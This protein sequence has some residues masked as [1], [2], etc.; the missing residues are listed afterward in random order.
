M[1]RGNFSQRGTT[2]PR[3][4]G[5]RR[6]AGAHHGAAAGG[7]VD[8]QRAVE[9]F[10]ALLHPQQTEALGTGGG[11]RVEAPAVV[12]DL[13]VDALAVLVDLLPKAIRAVAGGGEYVSPRIGARLGERDVAAPAPWA[14]T[15]MYRPVLLIGNV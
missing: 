9:Q 3:R 2:S 5:A 8:L 4:R 10:Y 12:A 1:R 15:W 7:G 6:E 14:V 13:H 11:G